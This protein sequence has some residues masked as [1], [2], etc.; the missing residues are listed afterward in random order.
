[1]T[2]R[3]LLSAM[4]AVAALPLPLLYPAADF[5][6]FTLRRIVRYRRRVV[7]ANLKEVFPNLS[8][9]E[10]LNIEKKF[11]RHLC[12]IFVETF[13]LLNISDKEIDRRVTAEGAELIDDSSRRGKSS[14]VFLGHYGNWEWGTAL[15][16]HLKVK[17]DFVQL[18]R[19]LRNRFFD[20]LM[21]RIR[22]RFGS[23][24]I[25]VKTALR[26]LISLTQSGETFVAG[27]IADQ[28]P[29][30]KNKA[31]HWTDFL[32]I[33]TAYLPGGEMLGRHL[34]TDFYYLDISMPRRGRYH[35]KVIPIK[36]DHNAGHTPDPAEEYPVTRQY[37]KLLEQT[38]RR[39][40]PLWLWSHNRW[41]SRR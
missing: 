17:T 30:G 3:I 15:C 23:K 2:R 5:A 9:K 27:F 29:L 36:T 34:D 40:P 11:Y 19:P 24:S 33:D 14:V 16:R 1:M 35:F 13:K 4:S 41:A 39:D 37:L 26:Q 12:D 6:A 7:R 38:I 28:R 20:H 10:R 22:G 25:P 21:L 32:G 31:K 18:Y 8:D